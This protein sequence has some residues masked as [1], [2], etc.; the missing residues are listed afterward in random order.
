[1]NAPIDEKLDLLRKMK[2]DIGKGTNSPASSRPG[3]N[4]P[5]IDADAYR[6]PDA[7]EKLIKLSVDNPDMYKLVINKINNGG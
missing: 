7:I 5:E 2:T 6:G 3:I 1:M 4:I